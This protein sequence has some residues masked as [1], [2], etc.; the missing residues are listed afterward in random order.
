MLPACILYHWFSSPPVSLIWGTALENMCTHHNTKGHFFS[1]MSAMST[2]HRIMEYVNLNRD[3]K[4]M[5]E[6]LILTFLLYKI[7][8]VFFFF[9]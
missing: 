6:M 1:C 8:I 5:A 3:L 2:S 9:I 7:Y 4:K